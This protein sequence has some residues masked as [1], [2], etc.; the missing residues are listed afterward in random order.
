MDLAIQSAYNKWMDRNLAGRMDLRRWQYFMVLA[1]EMNFTRASQRLYISQPALSQHIRA[2][3]H[4]LHVDLLDRAGPRF[5]LT[6]AGRALAAEAVRLMDQVAQARQR[7]DAAGRGASGR[8]RVA[9]TRTAPGLRAGE[10]VHA[11]SER[12]PEVEIESETAWTS[13]NVSRLEAGEID[14]AFIR[15][16]I[17][18]VAVQV[19]VIGF[20]E[21]L[22]AVPQAHPLAA[23]ERLTREQ[24]A[25][26]PTVWLPRRNGAGQ[27]D[28]ICA[29]IWPS[30]PRVVRVEPDDEQVI[31]AVAD[32][33]GIAP[34]PQLRAQMLR[35]TGVALRHMTD[36]VPTTRLGVAWLADSH[37][38]LVRNFVSMAGDYVATK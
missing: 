15:P 35:T 8:L 38:R 28:E 37:S 10:L 6:D 18:S 2:L 16:P 26:E 7:V 3:E 11:F 5:E 25:D 14:I 12:Y 19:A 34:L 23:F 33:V 36:P 17:D 30:G 9:Y 20:E 31:Q 21:V 32:G 13:R 27:M 24:V 22:I 1:E 29:Q 4:A